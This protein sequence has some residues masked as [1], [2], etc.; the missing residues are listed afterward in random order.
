MWTEERE[1]CDAEDIPAVGDPAE[2][3]EGGPKNTEEE[4]VLPCGRVGFPGGDGP[5]GGA[6]VAT[7][8]PLGGPAGPEGKVDWVPMAGSAALDAAFGVLLW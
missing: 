2:R 3:A 6:L 8:E 5:P 4:P 7:G 1:L